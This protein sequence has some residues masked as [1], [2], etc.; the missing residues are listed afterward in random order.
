MKII[1]VLL[2]LNFSVLA[3]DWSLVEDLAPAES[4]QSDFGINM[5]FAEDL[6]VVSWPRIF[7]RGNDADSC[8]EVITYEKVDGSYAEIARLTAQDLT[9]TCSN[10][11]G[12]GFGLAYDNGI[13]AIGMPAGARSGM[14]MSGSSGDADSRVF[15]TSFDSGN[16]QLQETLQAGDLTNGKGMGFQLVLEGDILLVHAHEYDTIF[17][18]SFPVS[19]GV[20]VFEK[21]GSGFVETQKL[22]EDF[23]LFGQDFDVENNQVIVGAWGEQAVNQPGRIYVYEKQG[24][25]WQNTQTIND[26]RN[27]NLGNQIE[28][29]A[30]TMVAGNVQAGGI[31]GVTVFNKESNGQWAESQF[32]QAS[33]STFNDQFGISVRLSADELIVGAGAGEDSSLTLGAVY[34]FSRDANQLFVEDQKLVAS[35]PSNLYDRFGGNLIFNDT[36]L[37]VNSA[38]GGF[39]DADVTS[40]H[41]FSRESSGGD[42]N[43]PVDSKI[44]G[45][46]NAQG[47]DD[48]QISL[49]LLN[50]GRAL[51]FAS[52]N[53]NGNSL[54]LLGI[55]TASGNTLDFQEVYSTSGAQFGAAFTSSDVSVVN[56]GQAMIRFSQCNSA[57]L[58]FDFSAIATEEVA[59]TKD[60]EIPGNECATSTKN[61]PNGVS[62]S[63]YDVNRSGEGLTTYLYEENGV[64]MAVVTWF[65]YDNN[66]NQMWMRGSGSVNNQTINVAEMKSYTGANLLSGTSQTTVMGEL[67]MSWN[68]CNQAN[69]NYDFTLSNLGAG[70]QSLTQ[71][72]VL[73][74]TECDISKS[75][76]F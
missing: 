68:A 62:G 58:S 48:Q 66:G 16:W 44:S 11:D 56:E 40:F 73:D 35:N 74:N 17:S 22:E 15:I 67:S 6:L 18:V 45:T 31:G 43:Y 14:G 4:A 69:L 59:L 41:H 3:Q 42:S 9:G 46:W 38:S 61:L 5:V 53:H 28:I 39:N 2:V 57:L 71:L 64:Q 26:T 34:T 19:T 55:G 12:F 29:F 32:I 23:H 7:T 76:G 10:G 25:Q 37:L 50:D 75:L 63:W 54:W 72:S 1:I 47:V 20:Y 13:L 33:D 27:S 24:N 60:K 8:G 21:T 49:E 36:D 65:T 70:S 30:D 51:M 52:L